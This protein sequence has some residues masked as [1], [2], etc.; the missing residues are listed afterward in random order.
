MGRSRAHEHAVRRIRSRC[1]ARAESSQEVAA[2]PR[3]DMNARRFTSNFSRASKRK[4]ALRETYCTADIEGVFVGCGSIASDQHDRDA[5][6][7]SAS[8]PIAVKHWHRSETPLCAGLLEQRRPI[9]ASVWE[10]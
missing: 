6:P 4:V 5:R 8:P 3:S 2:P 10:D 7:M 9:K 1:R